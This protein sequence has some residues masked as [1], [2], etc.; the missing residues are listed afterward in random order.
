MTVTP[1]FYPYPC[2]TLEKINNHIKEKL[3]QIVDNAAAQ[4][5]TVQTTYASV[6]NIPPPHA[7]PR[8]AAKEGIRVR[9]F[10][11]EGLA[12]TKFSHT[13]VFQ[14][15]TELNK[16]L[17]N[18]GLNDRKIRS[19]NR[20]R[21][22]GVLVEMDSDAAT[23]WMSNQENRNKFCSK[24]GPTVVFCPRVHSL[25]AFN[26]PLGLNPEDDNHRQGQQLRGR[27]YNGDEMGQARTQEG[28]GAKDSSPYPH[29]Q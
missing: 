21:N 25:I 7:N 23:M 28:P 20:L 1:R 12:N 26:V 18:L 5:R 3:T 8:I 6:L 10:L 29:I 4:P 14:L 16:F 11:L 9:Q 19:V 15:K 24:I 27:I 13:D 22:G 2:Y 17:E